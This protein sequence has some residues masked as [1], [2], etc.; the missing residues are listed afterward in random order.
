MPNEDEMAEIYRS[1]QAATQGGKNGIP[2]LTYSESLFIYDALKTGKPLGTII[3]YIAYKERMRDEQSAAISA[4]AQEMDTAKG[5]AV[6]KEKI[7][8]ELALI[9]AKNKGAIDAIFA[10]GYVDIALQSKKSEEQLAQIALEMGFKVGEAQMQQPEG[11]VP[12]EGQ[13]PPM[14]GPV[15]QQE[16]PPPPMQ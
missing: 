4:Q 13:M 3:A 9:D 14:Q 6:N 10:Q 8:G 12:Q 2:A 15:M 1:A 11:A 5:I 7:A 16:Q